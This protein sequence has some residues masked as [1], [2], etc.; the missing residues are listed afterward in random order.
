MMGVKGCRG[1]NFETKYLIRWGIP[2]W[3]LL[4]SLAPYLIVLYHD[5]FPK[6]ITEKH[7][8]SLGAFITLAGVPIGYF[9]NQLHHFVCWVF[10]KIFNKGWE[11]YFKEEIEVDNL[12][13]KEK[14]DHYKERYRYLLTKKHEVGSVFFSFM[15]SFVIVFFNSLSRG[16]LDNFFEFIYA[17]ALLIIVLIWYS[18][19]NY[20]S[21][22]VE[23]Y[24]RELLKVSRK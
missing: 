15:A 11:V 17:L 20:A 22:N 10:P 6:E 8:L 19:R 16:N 5:L 1:M 14:N 18:L 7:L 21:E 2:G 13:A 24:F 9:F 3:L 23:K 12:L 4:I